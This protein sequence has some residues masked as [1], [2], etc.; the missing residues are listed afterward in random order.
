M[1]QEDFKFVSFNFD[2]VR[3]IEAFLVKRL[4]DVPPGEILAICSKWDISPKKLRGIFMDVKDKIQRGV[5][6]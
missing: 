3:F 2:E 5:T 1:S 4:E 6:G